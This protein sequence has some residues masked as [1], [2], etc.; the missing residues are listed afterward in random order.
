MTSMTNGC[1]TTTYTWDARNRLTEIF[2]YDA[3]CSPLSASFKY[4]ALGRRIEKTINGRTINYLYD[5]LDIVQEIEGG[6]VT[7]NY[8]RTLNIDEPLARI[9]SDGTVRYYQTDALGSVIALTD[10]T[11]NVKTTYNYDPF[12]NTSVSGEP[13]DNPFQYTGR[14]NDNPVLSEVEGGLYYYRARYYSPE[15]QRFISEDPI[16]LDSDDINFYAYVGNSPVNW[17]DP[18]GLIVIVSDNPSRGCPPGVI[19]L[20][21]GQVDP[22]N[23]GFFGQSSGP[24]NNFE[25][26]C[27]IISKHLLDYLIGLPIKLQPAYI[28]LECYPIDP[29]DPYD[30]CDDLGS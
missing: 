11:G 17:V 1:G 7:V 14:E 2:G 20:D 8:I 21:P 12:G 24:T 15:L 4:D 23:P 27:I 29:I 22:N 3:Q 9:K 13:S 6:M 28:N 26:L 18:W 16:R 10:E 25:G 30:S 19:C 5:G